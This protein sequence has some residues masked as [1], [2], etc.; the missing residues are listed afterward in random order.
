MKIA[1]HQPHYFPW[2]GYFDKIAKVDKFIL[3][4]QVQFE[5]GSQMI[6]NRVVSDAGVIKYITLSADTR[7]FLEREYRD[8]LIK[9]ADE[10]KTR[11]KNVLKNYYR[12]SEFS[13]EI[14]SMLN[15]FWRNNYQTVCEWTCKSIELICGLLNIGTEL[16]Y[17]SNILYEKDNKRSD[18]VLSICKN[19]EADYYFAGKGAS[20]KYLDYQ[21]FKNNGIDI[22]FQD[23]Q[24][25]V[26]KQCSSETFIP[27]VSVIDMLFNCG[28]KETKRIFWENVKNKN[29]FEKTVKCES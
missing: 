28:V 7:N 16:L 14:M 3:L 10:W 18:L 21:K 15:V 6:R 9:N 8:I 24:H 5:K 2:I 13:D 4:D 27:G 22:V 1:I 11:Q 26:Y 25:P 20:V 29:E 23:F 12:G 19:L 17:Q